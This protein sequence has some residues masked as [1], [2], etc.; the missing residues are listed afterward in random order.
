MFSGHG[1]VL[2][3]GC[4]SGMALTVLQATLPALAL[5]HFPRLVLILPIDVVNIVI[6]FLNFLSNLFLS[7]C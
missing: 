4:F 2:A 3:G 5:T 6:F 7:K 1:A